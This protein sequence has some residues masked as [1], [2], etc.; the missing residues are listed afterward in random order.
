MNILQEK[1]DYLLCRYSREEKVSL[2]DEKTAE[3]GGK[4]YPILAHRSE[5]RFIELRNLVCGGTLEDVSVMRVFRIVEKDKDI[6]DE[7]CREADICRFVLN[8]NIESIT[9]MQNDNVLNAIA[10]A[11]GG[12]VCTIEIAATLEK[13][14]K[15]KDKH[16]IIARRGTACDVVVDAQLRQES[17]YFFGK[18]NKAVTDVDFE[19]FGLSPEDTATVRFAFGLSDKKEREE[20][21]KTADALCALKKA[22]KE[23]AACGERKVLIG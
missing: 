17:I 12:I 6:F 9:V 15:P 23:S 18:E 13:G 22:A 21:Q 10:G 4:R 2:I 7:L 8:R 5:R 3:V 19:I 11:E 20:T 14:E 16:E 1:L